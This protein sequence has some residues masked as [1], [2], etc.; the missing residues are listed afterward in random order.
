MAETKGPEGEKKVTVKEWMDENQKLSD[1]HIRVI[2]MAASLAGLR[3]RQG[4]PDVPAALLVGR[5]W[6]DAQSALARLREEEK[7]LESSS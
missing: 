1:H 7:L 5:A 2:F 4:A 6:E 3:A